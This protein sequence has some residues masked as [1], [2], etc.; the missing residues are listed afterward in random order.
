VL[1]RFQI[2]PGYYLYRD[3]IS[4]KAQEGG[5]L[6]A[7]R[8]PPGKVHE[9]ETMG[10][11]EVYYDAAEIVVP[12][13][14]SGGALKISAQYQGCAEKGICY[15]PITKTFTL[16]LAA[17]P[18]VADAG[19]APPAGMP[20]TAAAGAKSV[21]ES[22]GRAAADKGF[23]GYVV[24][25]FLTGIL[26]TFTPCVLPMIPILS[27]IIVGEGEGITRARGGMLSISYVLGTAVTYTAA[28]V[29]AGATGEQLQAYFQNPW[30]IGSIALVLVL[31]ALSMFGLYDLQL[32]SALQ[33]RLTEKSQGIR[34]GKLGMVFVMGM[35]AALIVGACVSPLLIAALGV[36]ITT[37]D[38]VLGGAIMFAMALGMGVFLIA[39]GFGAGYLIPRAGAWMDRVKY[40]FGVL[41]LGVA[42]TL[43]GALP[44]VPVLFLWSALF[45]VTAVYLGAAQA[46]PE[47]ASGWRTLAKG[48][49]VFMLSWGVLAM[50]GAMQGNRDIL[51]PVTLGGVGSGSG[52]TI[53][54]AEPA[55]LFTR[56]GSIAELDQALAKARADRKPVLLDYFADWCTDCVR[57]EKSTFANPAVRSA[58]ERFALLQADVT[59]SGSEFGKAVKKRFGVFGPPAMLF[60]GPD[61]TERKEL[62]RYGY[63]AAADFLKHVEGL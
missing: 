38:P 59:D 33:S 60:F 18:A 47:D 36:A 58:L 28:G 12:V 20:G 7:A 37:G 13:E 16:N 50:L 6:G 8:L 9:D 46:L 44:A 45:I 27:S 40:A 31:L 3:K 53:A 39:L 11:T 43:L 14:T 54:R 19:A 48:A 55:H 52:A 57:M 24:G 1:A 2:A 35:M 26:L 51:Q 41:L 23:W 29:V 5:P 21:A 30:A 10:R 63:M 62:R 49:G 15:A 25:A 17:A 56:V 32:P 42:I 4:F 34:G 61:G 22:T